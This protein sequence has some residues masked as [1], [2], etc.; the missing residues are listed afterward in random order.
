MTGHVLEVLPLSRQRWIVCYQADATPL[1][2]HPTLAEARAAAINHARQFGESTIQ[3]ASS[4]AISTSSG[5]ARLQS[6]DAGDVK[7]R[8]VEP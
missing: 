3:C 1:S 4:T 6:S 2:E 7:G 5:R 8:H